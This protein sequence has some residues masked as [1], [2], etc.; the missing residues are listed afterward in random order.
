M[1]NSETLLR[2]LVAINSINPDLVPG[3]VGEAEI[4]AFIARWLENA[5]LRR[6]RDPANPPAAE[7]G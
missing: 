7:A 6:S 5:G 1:H 4:A 3:A 2:D